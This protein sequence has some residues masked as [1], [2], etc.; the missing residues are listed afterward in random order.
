[1]ENWTV[2]INV[3]GEVFLTTRSTLMSLPNTLLADVIDPSVP[4]DL[5]FLNNEAAVLVEAEASHLPH[6]NLNSRHG[7]KQEK[8]KPLD[9]SKYIYLLETNTDDHISA[10]FPPGYSFSSSFQQPAATHSQSFNTPRM[11]PET[12]QWPHTRSRRSYQH[13]QFVNRPSSFHFSSGH[14][15]AG[16]HGHRTNDKFQHIFVNNNHQ[17]KKSSKISTIFIDRNP[18]LV[19]YILDAYRL[20]ELH[21]PSNICSLSI[22]AELEFWKIPEDLISECCWKNFHEGLKTMKIVNKISKS[23]YSRYEEDKSEIRKLSWWGK[24][25]LVMET[26]SYNWVAKVWCILY[27][28]CILASIIVFLLLTLNQFRETKSEFQH[29]VDI[30]TSNNISITLLD[31]NVFYTNIFV[32]G[33]IEHFLRAFFTLEFLIRLLACPEKKE[34]IRDAHNIMD[35]IILALMWT[36]WTV[37][38]IITQNADNFNSSQS[39]VLMVMYLSIFTVLKE[40]SM[41][42]I[43][44]IAAVLIF[45]TCMFVAENMSV[46][47][48]S[49]PVFENIPVAMWWAV[50]TMTTLGYGDIVPKHLAG[51]LVGALCAV[52]GLLLFAMPIA[53][54][55]ANFANY[56]DNI[57][58]TA[59]GVRRKLLMEKLS[60]ILRRRSRTATHVEKSKPT[61]LAESPNYV[62]NYVL[63]GSS[64]IHETVFDQS[65]CYTNRPPMAYYSSESEPCEVSETFSTTD[66]HINKLVKK[67]R[68]E[69]S[70]EDTPKSPEDTP[71]P[72]EKVPSPPRKLPSPPRTAQAH[73]Q[74]PKPTRKPRPLKTFPSPSRT[75]PSPPRTARAHR[76]HSQAR[77][78]RSKPTEDS[79]SPPRTAEAH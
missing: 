57:T 71:K 17:V 54:V 21:L 35:V 37:D 66:V 38:Y 60:N 70:V 40:L 64:I 67:Q 62:P 7:D 14:E 76:E 43:I 59:Q 55:S 52:S 49:H 8:R 48:E 44:L 5:A 74:S 4:L 26:P 15:H 33:A 27:N 9:R 36:R 12:T 77:E 69:N 1:M 3:G 56:Y 34:F 51:Y 78:D 13:K 11:T 20:G 6:Y 50:V 24:I 22:R 41:L 23:L 72:T 42:V 68:K 75:F 65:D 61:E 79:Q 2:S 47:E 30:K 53:V 45:G 63:G 31:S 19:P 29:I 58:S 39:Y 16:L 10:H 25:W 32:L 18:I 73:R 46:S 28:L